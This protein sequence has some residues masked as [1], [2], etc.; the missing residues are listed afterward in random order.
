M[1]IFYIWDV[2]QVIGIEKWKLDN[3]ANLENAFDVLA[4]F[5]AIV[6]LSTLAVNYPAWC[7]P[8]IMDSDGLYPDCKLHSAP[9]VKKQQAYR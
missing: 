9:A 3:K 4:Q 6:S 1:N 5:E 7:Q 8:E 2:R